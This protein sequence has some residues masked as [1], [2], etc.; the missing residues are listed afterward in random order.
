MML[1]SLQLPQLGASM[2]PVPTGFLAGEAR[3]AGV[4]RL[5]GGLDLLPKELFVSYR[6]LPTSV[7]GGLLFYFG[8]YL[9]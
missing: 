1:S 7:F 6:L 9:I 8:K 4:S 2:D 3:L 5:A